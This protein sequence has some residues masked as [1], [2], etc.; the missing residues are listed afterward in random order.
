M[1]EECCNTS[2][3]WCDPCLGRRK[4]S[5][6]AANQM[7]TTCNTSA[8]RAASIWC[9]N[10]L[11]TLELREKKK[12][13]KALHRFSKSLCLILYE[14]T[15]SDILLSPRK[16]V[17]WDVTCET[18]IW[19]IFL[20]QTQVFMRVE[21]DVVIIFFIFHKSSISGE[22]AYEVAPVFSK[23]SQIEKMWEWCLQQIQIYQILN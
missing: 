20:Y 13:M 17:F 6:I 18:L 15:S 4:G 2:C 10:N 5:F 21:A 7:V 8:L 9:E 19:E 1:N 16:H 3:V 11:G 23:L 22:D 14:L 12:W